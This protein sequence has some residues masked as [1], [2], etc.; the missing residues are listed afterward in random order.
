MKPALTLKGAFGQVSFGRMGG[1]ASAAGTYGHVFANGDAFDGS[2]NGIGGL[3]TSSR[4]DNMITYQTPDF[5]GMKVPLSTP[6]KNNTVAD[7]DGKGA[8]GEE[9]KTTTNR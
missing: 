6:F 8:E 7:A 1:V 3:I 5:A 9:G 4:Y 2:D